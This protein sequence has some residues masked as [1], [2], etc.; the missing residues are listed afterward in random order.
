[1]SHRD[2]RVQLGDS[3]TRLVWLVPSK[4][5]RTRRVLSANV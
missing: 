2:E 3:V 4:L 5:S 1:M